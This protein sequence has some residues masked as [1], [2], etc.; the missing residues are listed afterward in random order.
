MTLEQIRE[1]VIVEAIA[2]MERDDRMRGIVGRAI[3]DGMLL[4]FRQ[5]LKALRIKRAMR[6]DAKRL[7]IHANELREWDV[8]DDGATAALIDEIATRIEARYGLTIKG[9]GKA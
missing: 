1:R 3:H 8:G 5:A 9:E 7:R 4:G 6:K 2:D